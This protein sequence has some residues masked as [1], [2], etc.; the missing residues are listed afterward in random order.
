[1]Q[2]ASMPA[3]VRAA[4]IVTY[5]CAAIT[6][7]MTLLM[8]LFIAYVGRF[9]FGSFERSDRSAMVFVVLA[10]VLFS[11]GCSA[12]ACWFAWQTGR[13]KGWARIGLA[14]CSGL[15]VVFSLLSFSP[16]SIVGI[17]GG[18][19]VLVLLFVPESNAWFSDAP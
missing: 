1:M 13:R 19:A 7:A 14:V 3:T 2:P 11:L 12:V 17:L 16:P 8:L 18:T 15:T 6:V 5:V 10:G 4:T 9:V